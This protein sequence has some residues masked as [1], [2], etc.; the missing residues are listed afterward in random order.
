MSDGPESTQCFDT[1][2]TLEFEQQRERE[3]FLHFIS[4]QTS[5]IRM[6]IYEGKNINIPVEKERMS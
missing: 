6:Y 1:M 3:N 4:C 2:K 5:S